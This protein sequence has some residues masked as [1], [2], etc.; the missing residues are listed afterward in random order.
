MKRTKPP[1]RADHVGSFLRSAPIKDARAKR[2][3]GRDQRRRAQGGR[4]SRDREADQEA[5]RGRPEARDRRRVP[6]LVVALRLLRHARRRRDLRARPRHPVPGRAD[7]AARASASRARSASPTHPMLEH[8]KFLQGAH[9]G[10]AE[11]DASRA[12]PCCISASSP[13]RVDTKFYPDRDAIFDDLA[14]G[15]PAGGQGLLRRRLP[16]PA[17][18]RHRLGLSLLRGRDEEGQGA[19]HEHRR[20]AERLRARDQPSRSKASPPT[21]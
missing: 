4:G 13:V 16:L 15:L 5:G 14:Q 20:L 12:R 10:D 18:R 21:W 8:F 1:Y 11:D 9:Q 19:R 6:P 7:Q 3:K 2:E 17:V